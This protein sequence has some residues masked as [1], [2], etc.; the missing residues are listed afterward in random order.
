M[1]FL[2]FCYRCKWDCGFFDKGCFLETPLFD[3]VH[4]LPPMLVS[5]ERSL[6]ILWQRLLFRDAHVFAHILRCHTSAR[7]HLKNSTVC[8]LYKWISYTVVTFIL[9]F[10][11]QS[12]F[13]SPQQT[14]Y[15]F[16]FYIVSL[17]KWTHKLFCIICQ[18]NYSYYFISQVF[19]NWC[20]HHI[21]SPSKAGNLYL[22]II[23]IQ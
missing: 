20:L 14:L 12:Y 16:P 17:Y 6:W 21:H 8:I 3:M 18:Q 22:H 10:I 19:V 2:L 11:L 9:Y 15:L 4:G 7:K 13:N 5:V 23:T 1:D